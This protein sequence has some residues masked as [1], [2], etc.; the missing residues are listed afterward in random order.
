[1][2]KFKSTQLK[3]Q[4]YHLAQTDP[5]IRALAGELALW[6]EKLFDKELVIT[7]VWRT[8]EEQRKIYG[9]I[10]SPPC[11]SK[12]LPQGGSINSLQYGSKD[13]TQGG[14]GKPSAHF[15]SPQCRAVDIRAHQNYFTQL[16]L[17]NMESFV[18][19][20]FP[21]RDGLGP[22]LFHGEGDNF[23]IHLSVEPLIE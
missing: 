6:V 15:C 11:G 5:R 19:K 17:E 4:F 10:N 1:M 2:F 22:I 18:R 7:C 16:Q 13:S 14:E 3:Q 8:E 12:G 20:Y 9:S 21:R 23:H